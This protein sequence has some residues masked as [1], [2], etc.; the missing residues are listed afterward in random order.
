MIPLDPENPN[1]IWNSRHLY[2]IKKGQHAGV[3]TILDDDEMFNK[4]VNKRNGK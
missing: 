3:P 2:N 1:A 4:F